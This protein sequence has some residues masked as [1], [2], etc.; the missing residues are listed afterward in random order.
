LLEA[1]A[2]GDIADPIGYLRVARRGLGSVALP[3]PELL[4]HT[5]SAQPIAA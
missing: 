4:A 1:I 3:T 5:F 2:Q